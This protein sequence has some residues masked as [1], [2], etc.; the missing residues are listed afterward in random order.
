VFKKHDGIIVADANRACLLPGVKMR[1]A[2]NVAG[3]HLI[4]QPFF[5][6]AD[7]PHRAIDPDDAVA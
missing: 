7:K 5:E 4:H 6:P 1:V 2:R 3:G